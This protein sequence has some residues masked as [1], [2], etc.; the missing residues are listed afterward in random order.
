MLKKLG[1]GLLYAG[2]AVGVSHLVQSTQ[3]GAMF[4]YELIWA[5]LA[6]NIMKYPFFE[7][8]PR[9]ANATGN[10]L[11]H[12]YKNLHSGALWMF[13]TLTLLTMFIV[14]A[15]VTVVTAGLSYQLFG[16]DGKAIPAWL[17]SAFVLLVAI[18]L[19][20]K[21]TYKTIDRLMKYIIIGLTVT[22]IITVLLALFKS[23]P[24]NGLKPH[25]D[26][27][28]H[29]A[30]LISFMGWMPAPLDLSVWHSL[31]TSRKLS[32]NLEAGDVRAGRFDFRVGYWGTVFLALCFVA[33]GALLM[34][35]R[36]IEMPNSAAAFAGML[37]KLYTDTLG[38]WAFPII[39]VAAF[40]TMLSTVLTCLDAFGRVMQEGT[41]IIIKKPVRP[42][43]YRIWIIATA[44]GAVLILAFFAGNMLDL[45]R[46]ITILSFL[47]APVIA[48]LNY[49]VITGKDVP[50]SIRPKPFMRIWSVAGIL[51]LLVFCVW[52]LMGV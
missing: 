10:S 2:A 14:I 4:G 50:E 39:A 26:L 3:A 13:L 38:D 27:E 33:L 18:A 36:G 49:A 12:G 22:T 6:A 31:W 47:A 7:F 9:Y 42:Y 44:A 1:P 30:F 16:I 5:V 25:F 43:V 24:S 40:A 11:M 19:L 41:A 48:V 32:E 8:G 52:Y 28:I 21:G 37:I 34:Y 46:F 51:F 35:G 17:M 15:A 20:Y 45:V 23:T 29:F